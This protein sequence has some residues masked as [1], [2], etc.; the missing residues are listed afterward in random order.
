MNGE[1]G[2]GIIK[3]VEDEKVVMIVIGICGMGIICWKLFGSVSE[4]VIY[5]LLVLVLVC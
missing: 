4:Y 1:L 3:V 5:Y 2:Y